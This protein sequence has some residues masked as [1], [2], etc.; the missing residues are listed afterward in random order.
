[1]KMDQTRLETAFNARSGRILGLA[2]RMLGSRADAEDILQ[3]TWL[4]ASGATAEIKNPEAYLVTVA[5]RLCLDRL[6]SASRQR[7]SYVG[8][9]LPEPVLSTDEFSPE[10]A[11]ELADDLSFALL[12]TLETLSPPERAAFL[13]HD[14]FDLPYAE[15]APT[16]DKSEAACRQLAARARKAVKGPRPSRPVAPESYQN[17]LARFFETL[18]TG[19]LDGLKGLLSQEVTLHADGG[20][21]KLAAI[22]PIHGDDKVARFFLGVAGKAAAQGASIQLSTAAINGRPGMLVFIDGELDQTFSIDVAK[23]RISAI[24]IVRNPEKLEK[25]EI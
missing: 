12:M 21:V 23:D 7:E 22:N 17:L 3:E 14:V 8:P 18:E 24:Y 5:T 4:R 13:L 11:T 16:L 20:G 1:M 25:L 6:K 19:N 15:I 2:Y 9:W 10:A